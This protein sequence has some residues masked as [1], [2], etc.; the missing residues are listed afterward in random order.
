MHEL[1]EGCEDE[2]SPAPGKDVSALDWMKAKGCTPR[3]IA[4][5]DACYANDFGCSLKNLGVREMIE[6]NKRWDSGESYLLMDRTMGYV[7]EQL[8]KGLDVRTSWPVQSVEYGAGG[9][10][11]VCA[12]GRR[13]RC[14]KVLVTASL[15][16]L[17]VRLGN[18][19]LASVVITVIQ[20]ED[21]LVE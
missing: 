2:P 8:A 13:V 11:V 7:P 19:T 5:A 10:L 21:F 9:A 20:S 12:D 4:V 16:V 3:Q 1:F 14:Q 15:K 18:P 6:E 17:Q